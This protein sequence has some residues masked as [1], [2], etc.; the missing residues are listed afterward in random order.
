MDWDD[1]RVFLALA[2]A[3][4]VSGAGKSLGVNHTTV[5]RRVSALEAS[6]GTRLFDRSRDGYALTQA[7]ENM[8]PFAEDME[9]QAHSIDRAAFGRDAAL[10]G[11]LRITVPY[12]FANSVVIPAVP[13]FLARYPDIELELLTTT[14]QLDLA[15]R[16]A[17]LAIRLT[18]TPPEHLVGR[19]IVPLR[20]GVYTKPSYW[21]RHRDQPAVILFR[22]ERKIPEWVRQHFPG[23]PVVLRTDN[24]TTMLKAVEEGLGLA[25]MPCFVA[26]RSRIARRLDLEL[27]PSA[28]G[29][30]MLSHVDLRATARVRVAR[31]YFTEAIDGARALVLGERSTFAES[32]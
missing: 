10:T 17:D 27:T 30:W 14:G 12:D 20:H 26:D 2:R 3:G 28:W 13:D 22:S 25:R 15:A 29:V 11:P 1:V 8:L 7:G 5:A 23:A 9:A 31:D 19:Q 18:A 21:K 6:L 32:V 4:S 16:E 24:V